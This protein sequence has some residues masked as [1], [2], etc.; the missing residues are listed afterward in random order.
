MNKYLA[1]FYLSW[2]SGF[3]YRLN[4]LL[5]RFRNIVYLLLIYFLWSGVFLNNRQLF[6]YSR[7]EM[8]TYI[9][10][11][12][13]MRSVVIATSSADAVG[14]EIASGELSNYLVKP[15]NYFKYWFVRDLH[16]KS[17]NLIF[18]L[19]ELTLLWLVFRPTFIFPSDLLTWVA[20]IAAC[21]GAA[22][23]FFFV[24]M[25]FKL[26]AFW[27]PENTWGL[28]FLML[29]LLEGL[30]GVLF[31][32]TLLP[33]SFQTLLSFTPFPYLVYYPIAIYLGKIEGLS[34]VVLLVQFLC[35]IPLWYLI[36]KYVWQRGLRRYSAEGL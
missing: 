9:F 2:Q 29:V 20:Y 26:I 4:F 7:N 24:S 31:P 25:F 15:I 17:L 13:I 30:G 18:S 27:A 5:W 22:C 21:I 32:L 28:T 34:L 11:L 23:L 8:L 33:Q 3:V 36:T 1:I 19:V 6:D 35:M 12:L 14:S 16:N 10:L